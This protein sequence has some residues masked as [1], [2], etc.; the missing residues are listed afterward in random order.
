MP[1]ESLARFVL[2]PE[3]S[4]NSHKLI[5]PGINV[6]DVTKDRPKWEI[7]PRCATKATAYYDKRQVTLKD[8]PLRNAQVRLVVQKHRWWCKKCKKPFTEPIQGVMPGRRTTQRYRRSL[9]VACEDFTDLSRVRR[10]YQCS[11]ALVYKILY[12]QLELKWREYQYNWPKKVGID[13]HFFRRQHGITQFS[14]VLTDLTNRRLKEVCFGKRGAEITPQLLHV[15]GRH[16]VELVCMD[17]AESY[18]KFSLNFFPNAKIVADKFHVIR[19][20]SPHILKERRAIAGKNIT[21]IGRRLLL[22][23]SWK[24]DYFERKALWDELRK[25]PKLNELYWWKEHLHRFYRIKG[26]NRAETA[27]EVTLYQMKDSQLK[28]IQTLRRTLNTWKEEIVNYFQY[29][30]TNATTEGFNNLAKVVQRRAF[31]Y[32]NFRNYRLRVLSACA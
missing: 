24:L 13:E 11:T 3:L 18:R 26:R 15:D 31:G 12:E 9:M 21:G 5:Q 2:L 23:P 19:L 20:L 32:K 4:L 29:R 8:E 25:Y 27:M 14:T 1:Y 16:E 7:C 10:R 28:E 30:I 17:L 6:Y 22:S